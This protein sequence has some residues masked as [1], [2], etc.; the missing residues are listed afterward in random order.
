M[1]WK[2]LLSCKI[3]L[4]ISNIIN[5]V[6]RLISN[7]MTMILRGC[8]GALLACCLP[9]GRSKSSSSGAAPI[10]TWWTGKVKSQFLCLQNLLISLHLLTLRACLTDPRNT[11]RHHS[12]LVLENKEWMLNCMF[13][14]FKI[15]LMAINLIFIEHYNMNLAAWNQVSYD[16]VCVQ[17]GFH[18]EIW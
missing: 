11:R 18:S 6:A 9:L 3:V 17:A 16:S 14:V 5:K 8:P 1:K 7:T 2:Y 13:Y 10:I 12:E 4:F 15:N